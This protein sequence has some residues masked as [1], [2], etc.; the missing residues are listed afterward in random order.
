METSTNE[1]V[2]SF[3]VGD[4]IVYCGPGQFSK[5]VIYTIVCISGGLYQIE[6]L[7]S[8]SKNSA[9]ANIS[10]TE[11]EKYYRKLTKLEKALK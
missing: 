1:I 6:W 4:E 2:P 11:I 3:K 7:T 9:T 10:I 8:F 5:G